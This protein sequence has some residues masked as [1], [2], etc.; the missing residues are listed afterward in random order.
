MHTLESFKLKFV[1]QKN[2]H[3]PLQIQYLCSLHIALIIAIT[4]GSKQLIAE[5]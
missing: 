3:K 2:E 1:E 5:R 4:G